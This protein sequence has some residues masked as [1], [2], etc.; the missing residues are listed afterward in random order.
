MTPGH[1]SRF[2]IN[3]LVRYEWHE[4]RPG[5]ARR[6]YLVKP[7]PRTFEFNLIESMNPGWKDLLFE[8]RGD[9]EE[10]DKLVGD[11]A[12]WPMR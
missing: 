1:A 5:A 7:Y 12:C 6:E 9:F 8:I 3:Q 2:G 4:D 10:P 11:L